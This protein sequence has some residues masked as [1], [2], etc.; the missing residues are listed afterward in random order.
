MLF[1]YPYIPFAILSNVMEMDPGDGLRP[2]PA[3]LAPV[4]KIAQ[5]VGTLDNQLN[6]WFLMDLNGC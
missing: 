3:R 6:S 4:S 5:C 2:G 1:H